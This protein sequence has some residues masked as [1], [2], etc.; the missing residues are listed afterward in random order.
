MRVSASS[1]ANDHFLVRARFAVLVVLVAVCAWLVPGVSQLQHDDDVLAFLPPEHPDVVAFREVAERFG[2]LEVA[3]VGIRSD[4]PLLNTERT[5]KVRT[6]ATKLSEVV[7]VRLV[8]SYPDFPEAKVENDTLIV[9]PLVPEGTTDPEEIKERVLSNADAVGNFISRDGEAAAILI[10][11]N[12]A[13]GSDRARLRGEELAAIR[14]TVDQ[15]WDGEAFYGGAPFMETAASDASREDIERLSPIVIAVLVVA[16]ALLLGSVTAAGLNLV[17]T[18]LGVAL[19]VGA[20]GRFGEPF[21]IVSSTTPVMMVAL[22]GAFGM[23]MLAGF[24]RH[25]GTSR[26]RASATVRELWKPVLLSGLTT[27]TAFFA[28]LVMPQVPMQRFGLVAGIGV[29]V[30]LL[31]ALVAMPALLAVLP[32]RLLPT[33]E[34]P[35]LPLRWVPPLWLVAV[36]GIGAAALGSQL[37]PDPDTSNLFDEDSG[38]RKA[39][40]FFDDHFGGSQFIQ[41]AVEADLTQPIVLRE[42]RDMQTEL[43]AVEGVVEVRSVVGPVATVSEGF[44]GRRGVPQ[45]YPRTRRVVQNLADHPAMKQLMVPEADG[46]IVHV[47][48]APGDGA[49]QQ[50]VTAAVRQIVAAHDVAS[51]DEGDAHSAALVPVVRDA[52]RLR[53]AATVGE[54]LDAERFASIID[55]KPTAAAMAKELTAIRDR[56]LGGDELIEPLPEEQQAAVDP[57]VLF[58]RRGK[59]LQTY[60]STQ[61][62]ELAAKDAE[63]IGV[64]AEFIAQWTDEAIEAYRFTASCDALGLP[65]PKKP[66]PVDPFDM[67]EE[68]PDAP[69]QAEEPEDH[70]C[71]DVLWVLSEINDERWKIPAGV[72]A[73]ALET[74][75]WKVSVT[76]QPI[77]GQAFADSVGTSLRDSTLVSLAALAVVLLVF[78]QVRALVPAVWTLM[79]TA[80]AIYALGHP[81]SIGTSMVACI[82]LGAGVDFAIHLG[83]R[84]RIVGGQAATDALGGVIMVTGLQLALAFM[85]LVASEMPPLRQFGIGLAI[86]LLGA[87]AGAVW[88]TPRL[89]PS[90]PDKPS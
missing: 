20:H 62:P 79:L 61:L 65:A 88:L 16:S 42:I 12:A 22:G 73:E 70:R 57:A 26:E 89:F 54:A 13:T 66:A 71:R 75:P 25:V 48:M 82:A 37:R 29:L 33:R 86:G 6:L 28:L 18:G 87:A 83:I 30:L 46:A 15:H 58:D 43:E 14:A 64:L 53:L 21:T 90:T 50:R 41:I 85:V 63:G 8:L 36:L 1:S 47:K 84:A 19:I 78:G 44:G 68:E 27:S 4:G 69:A 45:T 23:H 80:G 38:P 72:D 17:I 3:L 49:H 32:G 76:G 56:A 60:L 77:I 51:L 34:N 9:S 10:Y 40:G 74:H 24:Q 11:L 52:V 39:N 59:A 5:E 55:A 31:L 7:G 81:I 35:H 67:P 2:M